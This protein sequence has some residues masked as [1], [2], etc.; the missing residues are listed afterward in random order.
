MKSNRDL[1]DCSKDWTGNCV[2][3]MVNKFLFPHL[4]NVWRQELLFS[5][6]QTVSN[7]L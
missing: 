2:R 4:R 1:V 6:P 3:G 7:R 5:R